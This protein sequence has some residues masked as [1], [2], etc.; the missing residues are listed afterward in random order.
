MNE[1]GQTLLGIGHL[2]H[3]SSG[4]AGNGQGRA[5]A[6]HFSLDGFLR[7]AT[8]PGVWP[9]I[10]SRCPELWDFL[11]HRPGRR[12]RDGGFHNTPCL[13][14]K[15]ALCFRL[16]SPK[17]S[18]AFL[19]RQMPLP[20][21]AATVFSGNATERITHYTLLRKS[22]AKWGAAP[23]GNPRNKQVLCTQPGA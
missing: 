16:T 6:I 5:S 9:H 11:S 12:T 23:F 21:P 22:C 10:W 8:F 7:P 20:S 13:L 18:P 15:S 19:P 3:P 14:L 17:Q 1:C 4:A 2:V